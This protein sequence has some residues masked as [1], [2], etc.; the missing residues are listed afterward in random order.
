MIPYFK[1]SLGTTFRPLQCY[2]IQLQKL[3]NSYLFEAIS[4]LKKYTS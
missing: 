1:Q 3:E 4:N 2:K